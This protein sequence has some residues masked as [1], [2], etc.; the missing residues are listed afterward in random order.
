MHVSQGTKCITFMCCQCYFQGSRRVGSIFADFNGIASSNITLKNT[1][2]AFLQV[3]RSTCVLTCAIVRFF[4][5]FSD[6]LAPV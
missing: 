2:R 4:T 6:T 3:M 1:L 5:S